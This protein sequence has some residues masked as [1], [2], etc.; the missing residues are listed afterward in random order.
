MLISDIEQMDIE[1]NTKICG[2]QS[3]DIR[4]KLIAVTKN[5]EEIVGKVRV[6]PSENLLSL[7]L[8]AIE[9]GFIKETAKFLECDKATPL[10]LTML[11]ADAIQDV[12]GES[13][14]YVKKK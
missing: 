10:G 2:D 7:K 9:D 13:V 5:G 4:V 11:I 6:D 1:P 3:Q 14:V 8:L 12:K